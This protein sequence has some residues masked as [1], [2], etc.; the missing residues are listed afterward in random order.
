MG[1]QEQMTHTRETKNLLADVQPRS[2]AG[3]EQSAHW[4]GVAMA[5][6]RR[7]AAAAR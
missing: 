5:P 6:W 4:S 2:P 3:P 7:E 1:S